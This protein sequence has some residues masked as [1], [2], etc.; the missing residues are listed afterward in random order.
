MPSPYTPVRQG[1][2][3][4]PKHGRIMVHRGC[5]VRIAWSKTM[6]DYLRRHYATTIN[7]DLADWL[8]VSMR[9]VIR[10]ARELG[11]EK[12]PAWMRRMSVSHG[13]EGHIVSRHRGYPGRFPKGVRSNPDGEFKPGHKESEATRQ[14]RSEAMRQWYRRHPVEVKAKAQKGAETRR[15]NREQRNNS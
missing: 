2:Y 8:G 10:K 11:L 5:S 1:T 14:K 13:K 12:D 15:R 7:Q 6:L 3:Y 4:D 9:T